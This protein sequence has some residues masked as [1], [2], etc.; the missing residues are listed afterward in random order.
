MT[1]KLEKTANYLKNLVKGFQVAFGQPAPEQPTELTVERV[2]N[3]G[4]WTAEEIVEMIQVSSKDVKEFLTHYNLLLDGL[5]KAKDKSL[6]MPFNESETMVNQVD[7]VIDQLYF[8]Y[9]TIVELG[10]DPVPFFEIVS[11]ANMGKLHDGKVVKNELGKVVK[12]EN[13]ERDFAPE[14]RLREELKKQINAALLRK[15]GSLQ[16]KELNK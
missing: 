9:G 13:W 11:N 5:D 3:R 8:V 1:T 16:T 2:T 6:N 10:I 12:P 7:A 14:P 4:I 15:V